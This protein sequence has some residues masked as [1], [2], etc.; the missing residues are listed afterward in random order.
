MVR[1]LKI[2]LIVAGLL[3]LAA[4]AALWTLYRA[5]QR[6]PE[7]YAEA[8]RAEPDGQR[9]ASDAMIE[10][11]AALTN[12][13]KREGRWQAL[14]TAEQINGWLAFDL[15]RNHPD[16]LP[17]EW[18]DP[19]VAIGPERIELGCRLRQGD[20]STVLSITFEPSLPEPNVAALRIVSARAG[21][22]PL[23]RS[24]LTERLAEAAAAAELPLRWMD[25]DGDPVALIALPPLVDAKKKLRVSVD[26][27]RLGEGEVLIGGTT[28]ADAP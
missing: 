27:L 9:Q 8:M 1:R 4:A 22:V 12:D 7:F 25:V 20:V 11:A 28:Q 24:R 26:T 21:A 3:I 13:L 23:S 19:R 10:R 17:P 2:L 5:S 15:P 14:F 6:V 16:L 18:S